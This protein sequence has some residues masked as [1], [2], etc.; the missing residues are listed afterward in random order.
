[1]KIIQKYGWHILLA[2]AVIALGKIGFTFVRVLLLE[3]QGAIDGD[4]LIFT[5]IGRGMLNGLTLYIDLFETKP[6]GVFLLMA[7]SL[8]MTG[9]ERLASLIDVAGFIAMALIPMAVFWK[10][11]GEKKDKPIMAYT[12][13]AC[14]CAVTHKKCKTFCSDFSHSIRYCCSSRNYFVTC[15]WIIRPV[16]QNISSNN[17]D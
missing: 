14:Y 5:I 7:L 1:M 2:L 8:L 13:E 16:L 15:S 9:G 11:F 6:P 17:T 3:A 12:F 4:G 10:H